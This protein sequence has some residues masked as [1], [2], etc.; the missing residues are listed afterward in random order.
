[1]VADVPGRG[2]GVE[3]R[4]GRD[5][6]RHRVGERRGQPRAV[7]GVP[8]IVGGDLVGADGQGDG[9]G[10]G[11]GGLAGGVEGGGAQHGGA[12]DQ[13]RHCP[14][15]GVVRRRRGG[16]G[17]D[18]GRQGDGAVEGDGRGGRPREGHADRRGLEFISADVDLGPHL[19]EEAAL[20]SRG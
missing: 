11:E 6:P 12:V 14:C 9:A 18:G 8:V 20:V 19:A 17:G 15:H 2:R 10:G 1:A 3:H 7:V 16:R 13:E 4:G 5:R